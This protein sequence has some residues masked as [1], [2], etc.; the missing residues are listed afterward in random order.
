MAKVMKVLLTGLVLMGLGFSVAG[1]G[2]GPVIVTKPKPISPT[3]VLT[4]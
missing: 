2:D 4:K 3:F 1:S